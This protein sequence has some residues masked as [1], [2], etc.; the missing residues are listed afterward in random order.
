MAT[1]A[2]FAKNANPVRLAH[3]TADLTDFALAEEMGIY[4]DVQGKAPPQNSVMEAHVEMLVDV[5]IL[6]M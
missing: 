2:D 6:G 3:A 4:A 5:V 1:G